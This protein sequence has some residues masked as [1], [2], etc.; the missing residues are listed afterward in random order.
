MVGACGM[1]EVVVLM[2]FWWA[3]LRERDHLEDIGID[4]R[5]ILEW[6]LEKLVGMIWTG[7][8]WLRREKRGRLL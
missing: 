4:R 6:I 2:G 5:I 1:Y 8:I 7:F 3:N